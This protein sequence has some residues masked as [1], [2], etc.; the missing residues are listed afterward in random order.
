MTDLLGVEFVLE[1]S[2]WRGIR[3]PKILLAMG[4]DPTSGICQ[5]QG[6][7]DSMDLNI[8]SYYRYM[9]HLPP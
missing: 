7:L 5:W 4:R 3:C 6:E 8:G 1:T 9:I 2:H